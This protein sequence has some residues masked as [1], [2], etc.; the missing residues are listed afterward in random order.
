[1]AQTSRTIRRAAV[2]ASVS[3]LLVCLAAHGRD[4]RVA[5]EIGTITKKRATL[6][7]TLVFE[8][9]SPVDNSP[10]S[11]LNAIGLPPGAHFENLGYGRA[12]FEWSPQPGQQGEYEVTFVDDAGNSQTLVMPVG[13]LPLSHGFYRLGY[14]PGINVNVAQDHLTHSPPTKV[15]LNAIGGGPG[16]FIPIVAA[17]DGRIRD[18]VNNNSSCCTGCSECNNHVWIEHSNGEFTKYTHF[19]QNSVTV[20]FGWSEGDCVQAGDTLGWEGDIGATTGSGPPQRNQ[21][22]CPADTNPVNTSLFCF[23]HLHFEVDA[24]GINTDLRVPIICE[25]PGN[26]ICVQGDD[27]IAG[28]GCGSGCPANYILNGLVDGDSI[29]VYTAT[30]SITANDYDV[31]GTAS[32]AFFAG[33]RITLAPGFAA[34]SGT[35]FHAMIKPCEGGPTGCPAP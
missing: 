24:N 9:T 5:T 27:I 3:V 2:L 20:T 16:N 21:N 11:R 35:Y 1:M 13:G 12:R 15:D 6:N 31:D 29:E 30:T 25:A 4:E 32:V 28:A 23:Y 33:D 18:I 26:H 19:L 17:A 7:R 22:T 10:E 8:V 34:R 14:G